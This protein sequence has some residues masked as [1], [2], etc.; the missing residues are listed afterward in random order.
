MAYN[1]EAAL[2]R[3]IGNSLTPLYFLLFSTVLNI[4]LD[5]LFIVPFHI[6]VAGAA[7]ATVL[8]QL[9]SAILCTIVGLRKYPVLRTRRADFA[10][11]RIAAARF[12]VRCVPSILSPL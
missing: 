8:S 2:L 3:A 1:M 5:I 7:W 10:G 9:L 4:G 12:F 6:G 11:S